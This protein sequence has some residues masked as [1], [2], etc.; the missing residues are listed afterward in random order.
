MTQK[1]NRLNEKYNNSDNRKIRGYSILAKGDTPQIL[2]KE[3]FLVPSQSKKGN[4]E[5]TNLNGWSCNCPDFQKRGLKCK[6]I[7]AIE[8]FLKLKNSQDNQVLEFFEETN[9][10]LNQ[11]ICPICKSENVI[12][13]GKRKT[14]SGIRQRFQCKECKKT[15]MQKKGFRAKKVEF[16]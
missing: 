1:R 10:D 6:H 3:H 2:D 16:K 9:Q 13:N 11:K 5:V 12:S 14:K 7:H 4:Y 15:H 8:F